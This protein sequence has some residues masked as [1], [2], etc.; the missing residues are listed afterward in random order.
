MRR[1]TLDT[2]NSQGDTGL[3]A[4]TVGT[5][6]DFKNTSGETRAYNVSVFTSAERVSP[7]QWEMYIHKTG[8]TGRYGYIGF[9]S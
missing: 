6:T 5:G 2:A 3:T 4:T 9:R 7:N 8:I 1:E